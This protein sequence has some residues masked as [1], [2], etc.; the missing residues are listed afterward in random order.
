VTD[1]GRSRCLASAVGLPEALPLLGM[2]E[3]QAPVATTSD[4]DDAVE[5]CLHG[6][7]N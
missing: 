3:A 7:A 4:L 1:A 2:T 6:G 5:A